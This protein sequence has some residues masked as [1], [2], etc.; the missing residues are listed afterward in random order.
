MNNAA[1]PLPSR[2]LMWRVAMTRDKGE[3]L[4]VGERCASELAAASAAAGMP[5][6]SANR[7]LDWGCGPCRTLRWLFPRNTQTEFY[8]CDVDRRA[9]AWCLKNAGHKAE[10]RVTAA[11]PPLPYGDRSFDIVFGVSVFSHLDASFQEMW[12]AE[13]K[14]ILRPGGLLMLSLM[15][16][17]IASILPEPDRSQFMKDGFLFK[18]SPVWKGVHSDWYVDAYQSE[19]YGREIFSKHFEVMSYLHAGMNGHQDLVVLRRP[20]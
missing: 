13:L 12:L 4:R 19:E 5:L 10:F 9:I 17:T 20:V 3:F 2:N 7:V 14:R 16:T 6:H 8:G 11:K 1:L 15:G 18:S